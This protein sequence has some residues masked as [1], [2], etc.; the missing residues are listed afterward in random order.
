MP[1]PL[2]LRNCL[3]GL[4]LDSLHDAGARRG[5]EAVAAVCADPGALEGPGALP[6]AFPR[7]M[8]ERQDGGWRLKR[9][10]KGHEREFG[11]RAE[12]ARRLLHLR[13][14][15]AEDPSL[16]VAL[17]AAALL[18]HAHLYV[19]VHELLEPHWLRAEGDD[20]EALQG[21][22]QVAVG[23]QHLANGNVNGARALLHDGCGRVLDRTLEGVPLDPFGRALQRTL[24]RVLSLGEDAPRGFDW[25]DV[26]RFP[27][28]TS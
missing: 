11:E 26:P 1:L 27:V 6:E 15:D 4:I 20:R 17:V 19:E 16:G 28:R 9:G 18:F 2:P 7:E 5:L 24:D 8:F 12:R 13:P 3:A 10:F 21:L 22:I 25:N 23:F 14:F